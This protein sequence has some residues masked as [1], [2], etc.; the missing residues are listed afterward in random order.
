MAY[1]NAQILS[2]IINKWA[3]PIVQA[4]AGAKIQ[5]FFPVLSTIE[6]KIKSTGWVSPNWSITNEITPLIE[7]ITGV[8]I[9]PMLNK[10]I[11]KI[12]DA[13]IPK[14]AHDFV[15]GMLKQGGLTIAEG[16][17]NIEKSDFEY[18]KKLLNANMPLPQD[19]ASY[20]VKEP[21]EETNQ[22]TQTTQINY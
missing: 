13:S 8:M 16:K 11:S 19:S 5:S 20:I 12:D 22:T 10:Y 1:T 2:A 18:L 14:M 3:Q 9:E 6:N 4:M 15:D 17:I 7:P 21:E